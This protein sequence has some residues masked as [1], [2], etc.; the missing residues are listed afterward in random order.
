MPSLSICFT[1]NHSL[2]LLPLFHLRFPECREYQQ[3][4]VSP[5]IGLLLGYVSTLSGPSPKVF[6]MVTNPD[7]REL[8]L[9]RVRLWQRLNDYITC[10]SIPIS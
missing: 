6:T 3:D 7:Q 1:T 8:T 4:Y 10:R 2:Y 5:I 9:D